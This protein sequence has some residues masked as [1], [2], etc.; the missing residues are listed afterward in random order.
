ME[1]LRVHTYKAV[2]LKPFHKA[3]MEKDF[4]YISTQSATHS[5]TNSQS[6]TLLYG[7]GHTLTHL[8]MAK[9]WNGWICYDVL[10]LKSR[11]FCIS[12]LFPHA[13][14]SYGIICTT[15]SPGLAFPLALWLSFLTSISHYYVDPEALP[16]SF[17]TWDERDRDTHTH[18]HTWG[19]IKY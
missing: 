12:N 17:H 7:Y 2:H 3:G 16:P 18:L 13:I 9:G 15:A 6:H 5:F 19:N 10:H 8:W 14:L 1:N 11:L 4:P